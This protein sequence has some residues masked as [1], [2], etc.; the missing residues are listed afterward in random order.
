MFLAS[1]TFGYCLLTEGRL[2]G[3]EFVSLVIAFAVFGLILSFASEVQEFSLA[4]NIV[5]LREVK[6]EAERAISELEMARTETFRF[7]L[8]LAKRHPGGYSDAFDPLDSRVKDFWSLYNQ[9]V[10]FKCDA[11]LAANL[12]EV[13][14]LLLKG[15]LSIILRHSPTNRQNFNATID[16]PDPLILQVNALT[17]SPND[18][19]PQNSDQ[20]VELGRKKKVVLIESIRAYEKLYEL[21]EKYKKVM[22]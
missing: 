17:D 15:Q 5:K 21:A 7:L 3:A 18:L 9:I 8:S 1:A 11:E 6:R 13:L 16:M 12:T 19:S 14:D 10:A 2:S 22:N 4:G 20:E